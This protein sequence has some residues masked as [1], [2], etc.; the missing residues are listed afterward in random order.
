MK[1]IRLREWMGISELN[2]GD[3][4]YRSSGAGNAYV[5]P[6]TEKFKECFSDWTTDA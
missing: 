6:R 1:L 4:D 5:D 2:V 3:E